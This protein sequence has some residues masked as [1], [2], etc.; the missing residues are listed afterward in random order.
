MRMKSASEEKQRERRRKGSLIA[1]GGPGPIVRET[2]LFF[3]SGISEIHFFFFA[4]LCF[5]ALQRTVQR[6]L[7]HADFVLLS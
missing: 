1:L 7:T 2:L 6:V 4:G 3:G 5:E